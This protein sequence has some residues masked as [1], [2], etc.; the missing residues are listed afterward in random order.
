MGEVLQRLDVAA[1]AHHGVV[2]PVGRVVVV[3]H[4]AARH[5]DHLP[6][7]HRLDGRHV[8]PATEGAHRRAMTAR[9]DDGFYA[10]RLTSKGALFWVRF[11]YD[12]PSENEFKQ[13]LAKMKVDFLAFMEKNLPIPPED[14]PA[15]TELAPWLSIR[16]RLRAIPPPAR[17]SAI[18]RT[19]LGT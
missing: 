4:H 17:R 8:A 16:T 1:R 18:M 11:T 3:V 13:M 10:H 14:E 7:R 12:C 6:P 15:F 2:Q 9:G 19:P 5:A